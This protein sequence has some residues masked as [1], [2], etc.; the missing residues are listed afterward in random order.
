MKIIKNSVVEL[1]YDVLDANGELIERGK[2]PMTYLHGGH[3]GIF[4]K[5]EEALA[6]MEEGA[7]VKVT[8]APSDA[9]GEHDPGLVRAEPRSRFPANVKVGMQFQAEVA[10]EDHA[11]PVVFEVIEVGAETVKVDGNHPLAGRALEFRAKVVSVRPASAEEIEH[12]HAH[13]PD[14]HHHH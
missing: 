14:G 8:L 7:S 10:H 5:V 1:K 4:P 13:G 3:A 2:H 11:H 9:F 6:G 12:G